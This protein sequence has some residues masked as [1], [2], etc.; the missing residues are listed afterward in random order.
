[1]GRR[2]ENLTPAVMNTPVQNKPCL[3]RGHLCPP[4]FFTT[5][6]PL[7]RHLT[8]KQDFIL[9]YFLRLRSH[10][11]IAQ[12]VEVIEVS[13]AGCDHEPQGAPEGWAQWH[14][15]APSLGRSGRLTGAISRLIDHCQARA[16]WMA[17]RTA[18]PAERRGGAGRTISIL[19]D[20]NAKEEAC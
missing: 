7:H 6:L 2:Q 16:R 20:E 14:R 8:C 5:M 15:C 19:R 12:A 10:Y 3:Q 18:S 17:H 4:L 13:Q 9:F 1:M 11:K